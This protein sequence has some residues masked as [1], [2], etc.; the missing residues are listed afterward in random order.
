MDRISGTRPIVVARLPHLLLFVIV[1]ASYWL[2]LLDFLDHKLTDVRFQILAREAKQETLLVE[3]DAKS[4]RE[5]SVWPWP[6]SFHAAVVDNLRAAGAQRIVFD[7]D[8]SSRADPPEDEALERALAEFQGS[9]FLPVFAQ[10]SHDADG[11]RRTILAAPLPRFVKHVGLA[12]A[13][14]MPDADGQIRQMA[15]Q[16]T[17]GDQ[18][19]PTL[20]AA[21]SASGPGEAERFYIDYS[22]RPDSLARVS[23][24]DILLGRFDA[25]QVAGRSILIGATAIE[26]GDNLAV[27][28]HGTLPGMVIQALAQE[29]LSQGRDLKRVPRLPVL[30][31]TFVILLFLGSALIETNW[32]ATLAILG[33]LALAILLASLLVQALTP[34]I[35]D[36]VPLLTALLLSYALT[37]AGKIDRQDFRLLAQSLIIRRRDAF[38]R[39]VLDNSVDG[40]LVLDLDLVVR[41]CNRAAET[42]LGLPAERAT[43][44]PVQ[45]AVAD[46]ESSQNRA[47]IATVL[48]RRG[49]T[50]ELELAD[51][52]GDSR[53]IQVAISATVVDDERNL[54]ALL[55]DVTDEKRAK[56]QAEKARLHLEEAI[57]SI[58]EGFALY[59]SADR[60]V[61]SNRK[62]RRLLFGSEAA[63]PDGLTFKEVLSN[64]ARE[65]RVTEA[66]ADLQSWLELRVAQHGRREDQYEEELVDG[67][68]LQVS[69]R[70]T[71]DDGTVAIYHDVTVL[72]ER[73]LQLREAV[74]SESFANRCKT[75]FLANMSHE[76]RTPLNAVIGF[77]EIIAKEMLGPVGS[78]E[79][80]N[81]AGDILSS[82]QH[83]LELINE[84]LDV[85]KIEAG[86][87]DLVETEVDVCDVIESCLRMLK[88]RIIEAELELVVDCPE[89]LPALRGSPRALKQVILNLVSN[90]I[91]FT[92][93]MGK[94]WVD[95]RQADDGAVVIRVID[96]GIGMAEEDIPNAFA[97]FG[98]V[99]S[100]L[101]RKFEGAGLGLPLARKLT[102]LQ[103]GELRLESEVGA[104]TVVTLT[105]PRDRVLPREAPSKAVTDAA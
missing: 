65:G 3:I 98:Q 78:D 71:F 69:E 20:F 85:A 91:K 1:A 47:Q 36:I 93:E 22:I 43:G 90:A 66:Q 53:F 46:I 51:S 17:W 41:D 64:A 30:F 29:S 42:I 35:L 73:E 80:K 15:T 62:F 31:A 75:E 56:V 105:F 32:R 12:S 104:G 52:Q 89:T 49:G 16:E 18:S 63:V 10:T 50:H 25:S 40:I 33:G 4:L 34:Y 87:Y 81:Y 96:A 88:V 70:G 58:H 103:G 72:K 23:Y 11:S 95:A 24:A 44:K 48:E 94:V 102:E 97:L 74:E 86:K 2:G 67:T 26:L 27:P 8:F 57:E 21:L 77:S 13:N 84:I 92:P 60:L 99:D 6:R 37:L 38:M 54:I 28:V 7:I 101:A 19:L 5:L 100:K 83:L 55:R 45:E 79:Y 9:V 82:G 59:D 61:L 68:F 76:L 14:V 39:Q